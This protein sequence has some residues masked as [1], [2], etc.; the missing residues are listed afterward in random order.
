MTETVKTGHSFNY[1]LG[2]VNLVAV[3]FIVWFLWYLFLN[4][5]TVM[6]LYTPMYGFS[7]VVGFMTAIVLLNNVADS[8]PFPDT[9]TETFGPVARGLLMTGVAVLLM[10]FVVYIFFWGFIGKLGV[11]YFSPKSIIASG[12]MGAEIFNARENASTALVY[13]FTAFLWISLF[14]SAGF[15]RW[16]WDQAQRSVIAWSR[17]FA[18]IFFSTIIYIILFHP[19]VCYLFYPAQD[20]AGVEPWW[21]EF[22]G[23][24]SAFFGLGLV[25]CTL[26]WIVASEHLWEGYPWKYFENEGKGTW[27]KG[28]VTF[29][30]T[31][32]MGIIILFILLKIMTYFWDEPFMGGQYTDGPD[33]RLIH[34]G[35]ICG[36]F[37]LASFILKQYFNNFPNLDR[38]WLRGAIRTFLSIGGGMLFYWFYYSPLATFFLGK[39]P[40]IAQP[41]DTPLVWTILFLSIVMVQA[42]FFE[43]WPLKR[44]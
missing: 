11:A 42:D 10:L 34:A 14:W 36:F 23:T 27:W 28:F 44:K 7:L 35:E 6:K 21:S 39:V 16:P 5:N 19:H 41:G 38:L 25:L 20:K 3:F 9:S 26:F 17:L 24:G 8:Y 2:L 43:G 15:G 29:V 30:S 37:I 33:F 12:G 13:F 40:G 32:V 22:V 18:V 4:P 31:I 1:L